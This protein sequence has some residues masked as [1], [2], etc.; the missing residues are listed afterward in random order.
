MAI[1]YNPFVA[2]T[3]LVFCL[4]AGNVKSY[5]GSGTILYDIG[6]SS[7]NQTLVNGPSYSSGGGGSMFFNGS[8][9]YTT[10]SSTGIV[11][12]NISVDIWFNVNSAKA[13]TALLGSNATEKYEMLIKSASNLEISLAPG[14][15]IQ[16]NNILSINTWT[17]IVVSASNGVAWK[18]YKNGVDLGTPP[19]FAGT[20]QIS[21]TGVSN[22]DQ[23]RIR[24]DVGNFAFSGNIATTKIYN[25]ALTATEVLQNFNA[26]RRRFGI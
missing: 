23:G 25:R 13:Y 4:D 15:Y 12:N 7:A 14:N 5:P 19:V 21:G 8:N 17:N 20:Y 6:G 26:I 3:G 24:N 18:V 10:S 22:I 1:G 11:T 16:H 9:Q 2:S